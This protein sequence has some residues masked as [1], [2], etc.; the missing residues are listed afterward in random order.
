MFYLLNGLLLRNSF[1]SCSLQ[2]KIIPEKWEA[3]MGPEQIGY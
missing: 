3:G 2:W 1:A